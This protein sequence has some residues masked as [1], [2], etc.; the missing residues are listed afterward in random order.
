[1]AALRE[2]AERDPQQASQLIDDLTLRLITELP[3]AT[4]AW[5]RIELRDYGRAHT[6][7]DDP[8]F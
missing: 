4:G 5:E 8:E 3:G 2:P 1:M 6:L 7:L